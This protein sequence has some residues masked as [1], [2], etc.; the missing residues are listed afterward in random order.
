MRPPRPTSLGEFSDDT[1]EKYTMMHHDMGGMKLSRRHAIAGVAVA[2]AGCSGLERE[3]EE[4]AENVPGLRGHPLSGTTTLSITDRSESSHDLERLT[5]EALTYWT[6]NAAE[7]AG[8]EVAFEL[9]TTAPDIELVFLE[10]RRE[11]QGCQ[12]HA[13]QEVLGCAPLLEDGHRPERPV[14][15][16]VVANER[17]YGEIL[18]TVEHELGHTLGLAHDDEP[19]YI[20]SNDIEDRLPEYDRRREIL[21]AIENAW[22][23][24]NAGTRIYNRAIEHWNDSEYRAAQSEFEASADRYRPVVASVETADEIEEEFDGMARP[25]TVDRET[26]RMYFEQSREWIDLAIRRAEQMAAAAIA[27]EGGDVSTARDRVAAAEEATEALE[28]VAFPSPADAAR[29][30]GLLRDGRPGE[31][32]NDPDAV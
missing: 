18:V 8:F 27:R 5:M 24:R 23:G 29:A 10:N 19:A 4:Q 21:V 3:I 22:N 11:L 16:E 31:T 6:T 13:S 28:A 26:L 17:P 25:E 9:T 7:Y 12:E 14:T 2:L 20:M 1:A 32:A 30:L 15:I